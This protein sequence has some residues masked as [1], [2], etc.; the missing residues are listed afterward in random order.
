MTNS[1]ELYT[2]PSVSIGYISSNTVH[3]AEWNFPAAK[4]LK[5]YDKW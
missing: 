3:N 4:Y 1:H 5:G 2:T